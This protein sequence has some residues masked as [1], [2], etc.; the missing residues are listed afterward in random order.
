MQ[1]WILASFGNAIF[2]TLFSLSTK[3]TELRIDTN[4]YTSYLLLITT[5][6]A[7]TFN[8]FK[9]NSF[10]P[11]HFS[12]LAGLAQGITMIFLNESLDIVNNP[13][14][15]MG[16]FRSQ[17]MITAIASYFLFKSNFNKFT[18]FGIILIITGVFLTANLHIHHTKNNTIESFDIKN[19]YKWA[20]YAGIAGLAISC[21]DIFTK[22]ALS[23]TDMPLSTFLMSQLGFGSL[24]AF[25]Y[26]YYKYKN[27]GII[28][29]KNTEYEND[30]KEKSYIYLV[31]ASFI[32][33]GYCALCAYATKIAPNPGYPKAIDS[34]GIIFTV[35][36]SKY[37]FKNSEISREQWAG[38][39]SIVI[40]V[41]IICFFGS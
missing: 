21:K 30:F 37:L 22:Y 14:L 39:F 38:V 25:I 29:K 11:N 1:S 4:A 35:F 15:S 13:G 36:L 19:K 9:H 28:L 32:F 27:L 8:I 34:F 6:F 5:F 23:Y 20:L 24:L 41:F 40:G 31:I 26:Q 33:I 10:I 17:A 3:Y 12:I 16:I 2:S 18:L 7:V